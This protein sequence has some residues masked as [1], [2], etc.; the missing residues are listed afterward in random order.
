[1]V[2]YNRETVVIQAFLNTEIVLDTS[3]FK[4]W[5]EFNLE[6]KLGVKF[7]TEK[8]VKIWHIS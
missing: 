2:P 1:M 4:S 5:I 8:S 6:A 3:V 7:H